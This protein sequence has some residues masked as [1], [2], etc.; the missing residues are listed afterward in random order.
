MGVMPTAAA[1]GALAL[2]GEEGRRRLAAF[3]AAAARASRV[4]VLDAR[5]LSGG[6]IQENWS[7]DL[8]IIGG[9]SAVQ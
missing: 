2:G 6:A 8:D 3:V 9:A 7:V 5:P 4:E 1:T